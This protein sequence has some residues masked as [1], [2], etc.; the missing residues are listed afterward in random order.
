MGADHPVQ[1]AFILLAS[2]AVN[3]CTLLSSPSNPDTG[4]QEHVS[5]LAHQR[6]GVPRALSQGHQA[7][8]C[9]AAAAPP[10]HHVHPWRVP[11]LPEGERGLEYKC[12]HTH[13]YQGRV[14]REFGLNSTRIY[15]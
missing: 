8:R 9:C 11:C 6:V 12:L 15:L 3:A 14:I 7:Q 10:G 4:V 5:A 1:D 2:W 13:T